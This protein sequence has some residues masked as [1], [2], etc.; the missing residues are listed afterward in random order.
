MSDVTA[1]IDR[2]VP[3]PFVV[4][5]TTGWWQALKDDLL[6]VMALLGAVYGWAIALLIVV[7]AVVLVLG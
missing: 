2:E 6:P 5:E 3:E 7:I 4:V 1:T